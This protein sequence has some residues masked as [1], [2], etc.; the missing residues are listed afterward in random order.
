[1]AA[2]LGERRRRITSA[3]MAKMRTDGMTKE[4]EKRAAEFYI[5]SARRIMEADSEP[6]QFVL[7]LMREVELAEALAAELGVSLD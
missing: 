6:D 2:A 3:I 4:K 5:G 1:M 7:F